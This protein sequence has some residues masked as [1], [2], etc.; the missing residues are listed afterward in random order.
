MLFTI[1]F[2]PSIVQSYPIEFLHVKITFYVIGM[3]Q[4]SSKNANKKFA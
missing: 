3:L 1:E 4:D 2:S